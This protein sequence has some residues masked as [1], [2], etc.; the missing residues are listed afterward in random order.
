MFIRT[1]RDNSKVGA[2]YNK[3][4]TELFAMGEFSKST[5]VPNKLTGKTK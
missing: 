2:R 4:E 3:D 5:S 1:L